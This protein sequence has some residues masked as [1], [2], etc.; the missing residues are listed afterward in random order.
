MERRWSY[1]HKSS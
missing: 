1:C